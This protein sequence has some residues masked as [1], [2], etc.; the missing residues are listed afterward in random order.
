MA[1]LVAHLKARHV[2]AFSR[3]NMVWVCPP[4]V[5][6]QEE[7]GEGLD[8]IEEGLRLV[9]A[10]IAPGSEAFEEVHLAG[11]PAK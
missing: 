11:A 7:L 9:D 6:T 2:Y 4:L 5:I 1:K 8:I 3:F 10:E